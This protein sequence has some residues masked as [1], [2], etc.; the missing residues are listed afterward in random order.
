[1]TE[2]D[3]WTSMG[4]GVTSGVFGSVS[5]VS[6]A[7]Y[8]S[9]KAILLYNQLEGASDVTPEVL[10]EAVG[11]VGKA[12]EGTSPIEGIVYAAFAGCAGIS[13]IYKA[14]LGVKDREDL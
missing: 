3:T 5:L 2:S 7:D 1:M 4:L 6:L 10:Q 9:T 14:G 11:A 8:V 13:A 12:M